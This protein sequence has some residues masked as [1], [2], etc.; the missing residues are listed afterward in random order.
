MG[1]N[2]VIESWFHTMSIYKND[3]RKFFPGSFPLYQNIS[4]FI[5]LFVL[6]MKTFI[7]YSVVVTLN[8]QCSNITISLNFFLTCFCFCNNLG[9]L[10][11]KSFTCIQYLFYVFPVFPFIE[12]K[13]VFLKHYMLI[14]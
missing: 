6:F 14:I 10:I 4:F 1:I 13:F 7:F 2:K 3:C 12:N 5:Y 9:L 11:L 8:Q